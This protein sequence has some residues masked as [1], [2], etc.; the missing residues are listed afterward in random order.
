MRDGSPR[1]IEDIEIGERV[2][3]WDP[4][5][6]EQAAK[7]VTNTVT[8]SG[9]RR[10]ID[11]TFINGNVHRAEETVTATAEQPFWVLERGQGNGPHQPNGNG[12]GN[13]N[14]MAMAK[15]CRATRQVGSMRSTCGS[16]IDC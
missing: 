5:T 1:A 2:L 9:N 15:F 13:T 6:G 3:A 12:N 7:I 14:N 8:A 11:V 4:L 16:A 10:L